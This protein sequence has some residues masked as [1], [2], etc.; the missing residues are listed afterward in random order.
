M[1]LATAARELV[2]EGLIEDAEY[3]IDSEQVAHIMGI[4]RSSLYTQKPLAVMREYS[5][6]GWDAHRMF[7]K[8]DLPLHI[9]VPTLTGNNTFN[10]RDFGPGISRND[11]LRVYTKYGKS[12]K[13]N[14]NDS[15]GA[16]GIGCK[17]AFC[18][19]DAFTI[20]SWHE[21]LK[22]VYVAALDKS[23]KGKMSLIYEEECPIDETGI[24]VKVAVPS[25]MVHEF[26]RAAKRLFRY[27]RPQPKINVA[28]QP[29]PKGLSGGFIHLIDY[30]GPSGW[31][32]VMGCVP[33]RIDLDQIQEPLKEEGL[34]ESFQR[35]TGGIYLPI[36]NVEFAAGREE[37]Q[38]TEV[39]VKAIVAHFKALMQEYIDDAI[40][41]ISSEAGTGWERRLKATF[42]ARG[43][44][45]TLPKR[46]GEWITRSV[47]IYAK[48]KEK[49]PQH[50]K[51][52][53]QEGRL[54]WQIQVH[55]DSVILLHNPEDVR[56]IKG[57][58]T[59]SADVIAIAN[60]A[61]TRYDVRAEIEAMLP[62]V[63]LDGI[64]IANLE[65]KRS[66]YA[67][68]IRNGRIVNYKHRQHTFKLI[69]T[70][71]FGA[72][73]VNWEKTGPTDDPHVFVIINA[74]KVVGHEKFYNLIE[75]DRKLANAFSLDFP[76]IIYGYK[77]TVKRP[78]GIADISEGTEYHQW[79]VDF[80]RDLMTDEIRAHA[81][82]LAWAKLFQSIPYKFSRY[83]DSEWNFLIRLP[84]ILDKLAEELGKKHPIV[85]YF[86]THLEAKRQ[87]SKIT[88]TMETRV[89][90]LTQM[91][92]GRSKRNAPQCAIDRILAAYPML[93]IKVVDDNDMHIF[94]T[95]PKTI[96]A[97]IK[98][99]DGGAQNEELASIDR[100][101][102][103]VPGETT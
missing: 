79:R 58:Q 42:M 97:Y 28:L 71:T 11:V 100:D 4:L 43:L 70:S 21:G 76:K 84:K 59:D 93:G 69:G 33:Y 82:N 34:L 91:Y 63:H 37:L 12:T 5:S 85:R 83:H 78:V 44:G 68:N 96:L 36:G 64:R 19:G 26:E 47:A 14:D 88:P 50:F 22:S 20:T 61:S 80:F 77:S 40:T 35:L 7:G 81:R 10:C 74:F 86:V 32:G 65:D 51:L 66:W 29:L 57:W 60:L 56:N 31:I 46:Y 53:G 15:V 1:Q 52:V 72:L 30:S 90:F 8:P 102:I 16:L 18:M 27:M 45:F 73:S 67:L 38:Y 62:L 23:N 3:G 89:Q 95:H 55:E 2:T 92:P 17:S 54:T 99:I 39:T 9:T 41:T 49:L 87:V 101:E 103:D 6:N 98:S 94:M 48:E 13:R 25:G 24:E 75:Q